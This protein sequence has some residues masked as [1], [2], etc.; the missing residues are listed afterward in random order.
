MRRVLRIFAVIACVSPALW[1]QSAGDVAVVV[2]PK[3]TVSNLT[4]PELR[5]LFSGETRNWP[6]GTPVKLIVRAPGARERETVLR[7]LGFSEDDYARHWTAEAYRGG[8]AEPVA[9]FSNGIQKEAVVSIAGAIALMDAGDVKAGL[10]V[11]KI[12]GKLPGEAG[13]PLH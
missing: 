3:N 13:Y 6:G 9:V 7:L 4:V 11:I 12:E 5:K 10:K 8:N 2:N 1:S